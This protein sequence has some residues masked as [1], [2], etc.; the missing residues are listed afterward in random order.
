MLEP[1]QA[2]RA[3]E[4]PTPLGA[5]SL[6]LHNRLGGWGISWTKCS[7]GCWDA[8][9]EELERSLQ[10][11]ASSWGPA[12]VASR[13]WDPGAARGVWGVSVNPPRGLGG[14]LGPFR[15]AAHGSRFHTCIA[16]FDLLTSKQVGVYI[17]MRYAS[18]PNAFM[19]CCS[20]SLPTCLSPQTC[21][22]HAC[23]QAW[24]GHC[25]VYMVQ[26]AVESLQP[27]PI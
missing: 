27:Q 13:G 14:L 24:H 12:A 25:T 1:K 6:T 7:P 3:C 4:Q 26:L 20:C 19:G 9:V 10:A 8:V 21:N 2:S 5:C 22:L 18:L 15:A 16:L 23:L 17:R 11:V